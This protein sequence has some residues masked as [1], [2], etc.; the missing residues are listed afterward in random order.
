MKTLPL[1]ALLAVCLAVVHCAPA[2]HEKVQNEPSESKQANEMETYTINSEIFKTGQ[3]IQKTDKK[4]DKDAEKSVKG[5][6]VNGN[7]KNLAL[8]SAP[9]AVKDKAETKA[10]QNVEEIP[11]KAE[12]RSQVEKSIK[13]AEDLVQ[14]AVKEAESRSPAAKPAPAVEKRA[15]DNPA[16]TLNV[17]VGTAKITANTARLLLDQSKRKRKLKMNKLIVND[18]NSQWLRAL[19]EDSNNAAG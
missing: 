11:K 1:P 17:K 10:P 15:A 19:K 12:K 16:V 5:A 2:A 13:K 9:L 14:N 4:A 6:A 18:P 8:K 3:K 7:E